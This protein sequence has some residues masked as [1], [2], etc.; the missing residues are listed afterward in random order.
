MSPQ[1]RRWQIRFAAAWLAVGCDHSG[2]D[3]TVLAGGL[4]VERQRF[5]DRLDPL[6]ARY[7]AAALGRIIGLVYPCRQFGQ[8]DGAGEQLGGQVSGRQALQVDQDIRVGEASQV[9]G[10]HRDSFWP[11]A[12][13]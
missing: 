4:G 13:S 6:Q 2:H 10:A 8:G 11:R 9:P 5:E 3:R 12:R 7:P 1:I